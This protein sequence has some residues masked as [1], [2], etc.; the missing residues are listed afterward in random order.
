MHFKMFLLA[1]LKIVVTKLK[2]M[3][4]NSNKQRQERVYLVVLS[5]TLLHKVEDNCL[6]CS[7]ERQG[8]EQ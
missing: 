2:C 8:C 5:Y 7:V 3:C 6:C 1:T 4:G